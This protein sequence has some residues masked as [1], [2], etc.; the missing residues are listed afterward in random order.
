MPDLKQLREEHANLVVI[1]RQLSGVIAQAVPPPSRELD[2]VRME[3][4]SALI[5]HLKT[6]DWILYPALLTSRNDRVAL[7]SRAFSA[8]MGGLA[9]AFREYTNRW[10]A[11]AIES[12]WQG[13]QRETAEILRTLVLRITREER[14]LFPL[15]ENNGEGRRKAMRH[16]PLAPQPA[17]IV[18]NAP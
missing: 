8:E 5:G 3:L 12:D 6:E 9:D 2:A 1:A 13:Y 18:Q 11:S 10:E 4:T 17:P 15:L 14:D 7:T 16:L